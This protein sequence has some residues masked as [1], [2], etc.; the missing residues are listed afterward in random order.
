ML[1]FYKKV[2]S[3]VSFDSNL[4]EK[5]LFKAAN[6]LSETDISQLHHWC[7][8]KFGDIYLDIISRVF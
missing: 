6:R 8:E 2:I 3:A 4:F 7:V 5:E 1:E